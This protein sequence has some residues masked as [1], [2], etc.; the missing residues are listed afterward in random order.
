MSSAPTKP[1]LHAPPGASCPEDGFIARA[2]DR[3]IG[4]LTPLVEARE[5]VFMDLVRKSV[6]DD[7]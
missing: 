3:V 5:P 4:E 2:L 1:N 6:L 7:S